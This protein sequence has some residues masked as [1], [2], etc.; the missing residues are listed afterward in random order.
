M[1]EVAII[2]PY[3]QV[4]P[5]LL[6]RAVESVLRACEPGR[7]RI[8]VIDDA[9][10]NR[11]LPEIADLLNNDR[12][13]ITIISRENGG[14]AAARNTGLDHVTGHVDYICFL[15]SDDEFETDHLRRMMI[16]FSHGADFYFANTRRV[17][18]TINMF[19]VCDFP[20]GPV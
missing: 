19:N 12:C 2:I 13:D 6:R 7:F 1:A 3:F 5:G 17:N 16:A 11:P 9:S 18:E 20:R 14:A 15:D 4:T 8:V 10:P